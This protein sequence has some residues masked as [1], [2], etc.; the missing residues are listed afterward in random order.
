M[1]AIARCRYV[2]FL[3]QPQLYSQYN[4]LL[5]HQKEDVGKR[6][7]SLLELVR[8][9]YDAV[10]HSQLTTNLVEN[11][12]HIH[13]VTG[14]PWWSVIL[15]TSF[16]ARMTVSF[17]AQAFSR[18]VLADR[19][20]LQSEMQEAE[21]MLRQMV[22]AKAKQKG[23]T[24]EE[25]NLIFNQ[26][27]VNLEQE[28]KLKYYIG[29]GGNGNLRIFSPVFL[30]LPLWISMIW[31]WRKLLYSDPSFVIGGPWFM[32]DLTVCV[33]TWALPMYIGGMMWFNL[34]V[35]SLVQPPGKQLNKFGKMVL[36]IFYPLV[37]S[38]VVL[39]GT[40]ESALALYMAGSVTSGLAI[41]LILLSPKVKRLFNIKI[42]KEESTRPYYTIYKNFIEKYISRQK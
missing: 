20:Q 36:W 21:P 24:Y 19:R 6:H 23:W 17:P 38:A 28:K 29:Q 25:A 35:Y 11:F 42:F 26:Q 39:S 9:S 1:I 22:S 14:L 15:T 13:D 7:F 34:Q 10:A 5:Y 2:T 37:I 16:F 18:R 30:Q 31:A 12:H 32:P 40:L 41:N 33:S 4:P 3:R 27:K 8:D